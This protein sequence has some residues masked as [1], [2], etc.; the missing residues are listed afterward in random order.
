M[1]RARMKTVERLRESKVGRNRREMQIQSLC[2]KAA[3]RKIDTG[4]D[5]RTDA[6]DRRTDTVTS[7]EPDWDPWI[8]Q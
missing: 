6:E 5:R 4:K 1:Q 2:F 7:G 8:L 3:Q